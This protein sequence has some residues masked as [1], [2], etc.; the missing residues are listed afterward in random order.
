MRR[1]VVGWICLFAG[2]LGAGAHEELSRVVQHSAAF[3]LGTEH[4]DV[5]V[6]LSFHGVLALAERSR[7]DSDGD[8]ELTHEERRAYLVALRDTSA[9]AAQCYEDG[10]KLPT[11]P[12]HEPK[13]DLQDDWTRS[14]TPLVIEITY[15]AR[16][17]GG[18]GMQRDYVFEEWLWAS[19]PAICVSAATCAEGMR[20]VLAL[21]ARALPGEVRRFGVQWHAATASGRSDE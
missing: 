7:M 10:V 3:S 14:A 1:L 20:S 19:A 13:I 9:E 8:G 4:I 17:T 18:S 16:R 5:T 2:A 15:F 6:R 21:P 12:L 11:M